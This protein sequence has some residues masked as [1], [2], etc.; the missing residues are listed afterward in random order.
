MLYVIHLMKL[1]HFKSQNKKQ[2]E[3]LKEHIVV[4]PPHK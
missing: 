1:I 2:T 3:H 4:R